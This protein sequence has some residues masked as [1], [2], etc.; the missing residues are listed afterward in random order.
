MKRC[1]FAF[2]AFM[3]VTLN[4]S[5]LSY[6]EAR[7]EA[8]YL[9]DKMAYELN[10]SAEQMEAV[11]E[12]NLD[13]LLNVNRSR[14]LY[15]IYWERRNADL[16]FVLSTFQYQIFL[17]TNYFYRPLNWVRGAWSLAIYGRYPNRHFFYYSRPLAWG[18]YRGGRNVGRVSFYQGRNYFAPSHNTRPTGHHAPVPVGRPRN[19]MVNGNGQ[20][21][22]QGVPQPRHGQG[23]YTPNNGQRPGQGSYTPN[24]GQRPGQGNY[25]PNNGQ[26]PGQGSYTPNNGQR[27]GQG[28]FNSG[29]GP[30]PGVAAPDNSRRPSTTMPSNGQRPTQTD[31]PRRSFGS[32]SRR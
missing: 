4:A 7:S 20:R 15:S 6:D 18:S 17:D 26:R 30:R 25:T 5:A 2:F 21:M 10:L 14:D 1:I 9:T 16:R 22:G 27:P 31:R 24:N 11:Y 13:Y 32:D 12:I 23:S 29:R 8:L 19:G 28:S 3:V